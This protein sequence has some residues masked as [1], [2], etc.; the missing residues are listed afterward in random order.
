M[1]AGLAH[2]H[3]NRIMHRDLKPANI[4]ISQS[5]EL[6]IADLGLGRMISTQTLEVYSKVGTPLYMSPELVKEQGYDMKTDIWSI[7]CIL[8]ELCELKSPLR[9][10]G[11]KISLNELYDRIVGGKFAKMNTKKYSQTLKDCI[12]SMIQ[13]NHSVRIDAETAG[14]IAKKELTKLRTKLK[15]DKAYVMEDIYFKLALLDYEKYFCRPMELPNI[16]PIFF[17][18]EEAE[19][20]QQD[21]FEYFYYLSEWLMA[22]LKVDSS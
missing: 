7:G 8:Y 10:D 2:L 18:N 15:I 17:V 14:E 3:S 1:A 6:K 16:T 12:Y 11:E 5:G 9:N 4:L 21:K 13:M 22:I 19:Y 20:L